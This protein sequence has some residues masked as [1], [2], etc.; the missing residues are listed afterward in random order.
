MS[1]EDSTDF[2]KFTEAKSL[3]KQAEDDAQLLANRIALLRQEEQK[4]LKKI[5]ETRKKAQ[6]IIETRQRIQEE[7]RRKELQHRKQ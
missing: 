7:Q 5:E 6:E 2:S 4:A 3:R 1:Q